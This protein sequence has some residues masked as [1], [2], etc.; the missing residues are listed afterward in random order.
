MQNQIRLVNAAKSIDVDRL[1]N[2]DLSA[3]AAPDKVE[4]IR[5]LIFS[6]LNEIECKT[7]NICLFIR[8]S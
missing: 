5:F 2:A 6:K 7:L 8:K 4:Q 3:C 1:C